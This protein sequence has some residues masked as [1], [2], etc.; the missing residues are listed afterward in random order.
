MSW[1]LRHQAMECRPSRAYTTGHLHCLGAHAAKLWNVAPPGLRGS[2]TPNKGFRITAIPHYVVSPLQGLHDW[3]SELS[4]GLRHQAM[5]C[6]PSRAKRFSYS[7]RGF[8]DAAN[9][10]YCVA[11]PGLAGVLPTAAQMRRLVGLFASLILKV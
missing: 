8:R 9:P 11:P 3:T 10:R 5:A 2:A 7:Q 6:R 4:W 1:G